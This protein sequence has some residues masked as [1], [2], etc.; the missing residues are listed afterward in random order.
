[1]DNFTAAVNK[2][3]GTA[4]NQ[5]KLKLFVSA[6]VGADQAALAGDNAVTNVTYRRVDAASSAQHDVSHTPHH[7]S[8][9]P[10]PVGPTT[11]P[12]PNPL[13]RRP[14]DLFRQRMT[15]TTILA[16]MS[17]MQAAQDGLFRTGLLMNETAEQ[18]DK[19]LKEWQRQ[20]RIQAWKSFIFG[21][22]HLGLSSIAPYYA[23]TSEG[24]KVKPDRGKSPFGRSSKVDPT[25]RNS[26]TD[27]KQRDDYWKQQETSDK[28]SR[29]SRQ[30]A[31]LSRDAL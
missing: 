14:H 7:Y 24:S 19:D 27:S 25:K 8:S 29:S 17:G 26:K 9:G 1:M 2:L 11:S 18:L 28:G 10:R 16:A 6:T 31:P 4:M 15:W 5:Q 3:E 21:C 12:S 20:Q 13:P 30:S 22:V 23:I